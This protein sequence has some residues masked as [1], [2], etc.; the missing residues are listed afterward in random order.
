MDEDARLP[1]NSRA[2]LYFGIHVAE[3]MQFRCHGIRG[4]KPRSYLDEADSGSHN[5][6]TTQ[7]TLDARGTELTLTGSARASRLT[8][9]MFRIS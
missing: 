8:K 2:I 3:S 1:G 5:C 9:S 6:V 7:M 4:H